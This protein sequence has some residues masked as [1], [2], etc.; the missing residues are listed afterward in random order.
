MGVFCRVSLVQN[1]KIVVVNRRHVPLNPLFIAKNFVTS[2]EGD[3]A[4]FAKVVTQET[5]AKLIV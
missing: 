3:S 1:A 2:R 4:V 5:C